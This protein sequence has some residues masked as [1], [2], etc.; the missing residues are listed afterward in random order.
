MR[1]RTLRP[2]FFENDEL[3]RLPDKARLLFAGLWLLADR[4]GRLED[5]PV[6]IAG[7]LFPYEKDLDIDPLLAALAGA[8][9]ISRYVV[10]G[11]RCLHVTKFAV[12][13][14]I[15]QH[16]TASVLPAPPDPVKRTKTRAKSG[17]RDMSRH[18]PDMSATSTS[19]STSTLTSAST[20][21]STSASTSTATEDQKKPAAPAR[22]TADETTPAFRTYAAIATSAVNDTLLE[23]K[24]VDV[25]VITEEFKRR[26]AAQHLD[27]G[28]TIAQR[29][30]DAAL[31]ARSRKQAEFTSLMAR[32]GR[33]PA[34]A[35]H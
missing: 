20:S 8:G 25:G 22:A 6:R 5:R 4:S 2:G 14:S 26:C 1:S 31:E 29:A 9:F 10:D 13:Q 17:N 30:V 7:V 19:T 23:H 12:H 24:R 18:R 11:V 34:K 15:H 27:Y 3:A 16:E 28:G 33:A 35:A 21:G 32:R